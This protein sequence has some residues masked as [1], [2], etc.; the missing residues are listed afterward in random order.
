MGAVYSQTLAAMS[1]YDLPVT[2]SVASGSLPD[3]LTLD[4]DTGVI[5]GTPT[6]MGTFDFT[7]Q[8]DNG[9]PTPT[10]QALSITIEPAEDPFVAV[11]DIT[12]VPASATAGAP[13]TLSGTVAP[14]NATSKTLAWSLKSAG[15]T[16]AIVSG[17]TFT[18]SAAGTA[19]VTATIANGAAQGATF[20]KDF[21]ITVASSVLPD[22]K[23]NDVTKPAP[24]TIKI[25]F[26][27]NGGKVSGKTKLVKSVKRDA[28]LGKLKAPTRKGYTFKGWY[29]KKSGGKKISANTKATKDISY[30]AQWK[31]A[32]PKEKVRYGKVVATA[33]YVRRIPSLHINLAPVVGHLK[34]G[35]T[36]KIQSF[37]DNP[38][39][40]TDWYTFKYKGKTRYV[41]AKYI[42][43]I[44]R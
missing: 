33:V 27:A 24:V 18:A 20:T 43:I 4:A 11:T 38:G 28:K 32:E 44:R 8:A 39:T 15:E 36:F 40:R 41:Y 26:N 35:Q 23:G 13:L 7:I 3:G 42:K 1:A 30:Y 10:T 37:L 17:D 14:Q 22:D 31:K 25:T 29:T 2:W 34:R 16:G 21:T 5:S 6:V 19:T 12:D 9:A